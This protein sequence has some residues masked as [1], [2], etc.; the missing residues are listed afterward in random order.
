M[1]REQELKDGAG[2]VD[3]SA[4]VKV[5]NSSDRGPV[6]TDIGLNPDCVRSD[7]RRSKTLESM[8]G[9]APLTDCQFQEYRAEIMQCLD[10]ILEEAKGVRMRAT[11]MQAG[12]VGAIRRLQQKI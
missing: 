8:S 5:M 10:V 11:E 7:I 4:M 12:I 2:Y 1:Q 9:P 3:T 6:G